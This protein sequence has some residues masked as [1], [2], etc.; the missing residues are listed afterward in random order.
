MLLG[1]VINKN[2][3]HI[4]LSHL[5]INLGRDTKHALQN[6]NCHFLKK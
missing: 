5:V 1:A 3:K 6:N 2:L 4:D